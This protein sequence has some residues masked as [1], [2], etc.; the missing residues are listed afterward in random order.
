MNNRKQNQRFC[1]TIPKNYKQIGEKM[2]LA[3]KKYNLKTDAILLLHR[4]NHSVYWI[5]TASEA[6]LRNNIYLI[7]DGNEGIVIDCGSKEDFKSTLNRIK[8]VMPIKNINRLFINHQDPDVSSGIVDWIKLNPN[9]EIMTSPN[10][11]VLLKH[12]GVS[13]Y[14]YFNTQTNPSLILKSGAILEFIPSPFMHSPGAITIYNKTLKSLFSG[15]IWAAISMEWEL[16]VQG[17]FKEHIESMDFF[18]K[19][20]IASNKASRNFLINFK[21]RPINNILPQHGSIITKTNVKNA[22]KYLKNLKCG[23][24]FFRDISDKELSFI[25]N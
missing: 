4:A 12:Y 22:M 7:K 14:K 23:T 1:L 15:D 25:D 6:V 3:N 13:D 17:D 20:Y 11:N 21:N 5:G 16:I 19:D 8:Q 24:D 10:I 18:H 2:N 9:I